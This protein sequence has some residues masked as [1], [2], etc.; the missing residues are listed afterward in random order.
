MITLLTMAFIGMLIGWMTNVIAI[1]LMFR[2]IKPIRVPVVHY[3]IQGLIPKRHAEIAKS[4]ADTV[5]HELLD[6]EILLDRM[7]ESMDKKATLMYLEDKLT[8]VVLDNLPGI[9]QAFSGKIINYIHEMIEKHG[10]QLL[11]DITEALIHKATQE[12]KISAIVEEKILAFELEKLEDIIIALA[13]RELKQ[14]E[15]LGGVLGGVIGLVQ[16]LLVLYV[17]S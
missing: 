11:I 13:K 17:L 5:E 2:P 15:V 14:I 9:M 10:D 3:V 1:K 8:K 12:V 16:G 6:L 4:V 7:I